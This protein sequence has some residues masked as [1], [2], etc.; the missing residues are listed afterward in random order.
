MSENQLLSE[1]E[2]VKYELKNTLWVI[3]DLEHRINRTIER[4]QQIE[5]QIVKDHERTSKN[6]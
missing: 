3:A 1:L 6:T 5:N 2:K 4:C